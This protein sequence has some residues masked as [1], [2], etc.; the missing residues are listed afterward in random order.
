VRASVQIDALVIELRDDT[1]PTAERL[2]V[3]LKG[4]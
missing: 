3:G 1:Q 4:S 2:D